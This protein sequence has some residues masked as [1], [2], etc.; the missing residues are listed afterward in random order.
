M[1]QGARDRDALALSARELI[2]ELVALVAEAELA[3]QLDATLGRRRVGAVQRELQADVL[4][5]GEERQQVVGLEDEPE[6]VA[7][8]ARALALGQARDLVPADRHAAGGRRLEPA[9]Q[10]EQRRLPAAARPGDRR[11]WCPARTSSVIPSTA[12]TSPAGVA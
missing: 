1:D 5:R 7:A 2:G 8:Q 12:R 10:A 11:G 6:L 9:D 4:D 3:E